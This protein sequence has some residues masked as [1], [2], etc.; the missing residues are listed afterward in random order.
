MT[1]APGTRQLII[2]PSCGLANRLRALISAQRLADLSGRRL[3]VIWKPSDAC[4]C[5]F[6]ELFVNEF[7]MLDDLTAVNQPG[8]VRYTRPKPAKV[9]VFI[10][11][12]TIYIDL[13]AVLRD[14]C[15]RVIPW[16]KLAVYFSRLKPVARVNDAVNVFV[17]D[18]FNPPILGVHIR[19]GD[20]PHH[21]KA[22]A[23]GLLHASE[24]KYIAEIDVCLE[25]MPD[26]TLFVASDDGA[27]DT[28]DYHD[29]SYASTGLMERLRRRYG[30][31]LV[32]YPKSSLNRHTP[33]GIQDGLIDLLLLNHADFVIGTVYSG[34]SELSVMHNIGRGKARKSCLKMINPDPGAR[35]QE[36]PSKPAPTH[37]P[38]TMSRMMTLRHKLF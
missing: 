14:P 16:D 6:S 1:A 30:A 5:H 36:A 22:Q 24:E 26:A 27:P 12:E 25:S 19:R 34:F 21:R 38:W 13:C 11:A 32:F 2:Q 37:Q 33:E 4:G 31:R 29:Y 15:E 8:V 28:I 35:P 10:A 3:S 23:A 17:K 20:H 9:N 18:H 7:D